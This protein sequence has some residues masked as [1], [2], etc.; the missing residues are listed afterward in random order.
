MPMV[1]VETRVSE[2]EGQ[3]VLAFLLCSTNQHLCWCSLPANR[4]LGLEGTSLNDVLYKHTAFLNLVDPISH[5]LLMSLARDIQ[6]PKKELESLKSAEK[7]CRQLI[8]HLTPHSKWQ[9]Q[10]VSRH[11]QPCL[12]TALQKKI[13]NDSLD[14]SGMPLPPRDVQRVAYHL[15]LNRDHLTSIDLSFTELTDDSLQFLLPFLAALPKLTNLALNGN[16]LTRLI[17]KD[18]TEMMKEPNVFPALS[19]IDLG[20]NADICSMPQPLLV[21]LRR[22]CS[23]QGALPTIQEHS[24][25]QP[26]D[27]EGEHGV[28]QSREGEQGE[29]SQ[30]REGE[31]W[32]SQSRE[33]EQEVSQYRE[34]EQGVSQSREEQLGVSQ[35]REEELGDVTQSQEGVQGVVSQS[36][37]EEPGDVTQSREEEPGDVTQ[38]QEEEQ[39]VSRSQEEEPGD[40][41]QSQEEEPGDVTQSQEEEQ[42]VSQSQE[43]E[44]GDVTQSQEEEQGVSQSQEEEPGDVTQSQEEEQGVSQSQEEEPGDIT[45]SQ[46]EEPGDVTQ[47]QKEEQGVNQSQEEE[48]GDVTQSQ[49]GDGSPWQVLQREAGAQQH[50]QR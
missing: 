50:C 32:I 37:E 38:S 17:L 6:C 20:N 15:Q 4:D 29:V 9:R 11:S 23:L 26:S 39:G 12:K 19:W 46:E 44:P 16:R 14:L 8:Y 31:Q 28:S 22:R 49:E 45:Q 34:K 10:A 30:S 47:S 2:V 42:G 35:S 24:E 43:E 7:L 1:V 5:D 33:G 21:G 18:M 41:T 40:V 48:P 25:G 13:G 36:Q 27:Q 3:S